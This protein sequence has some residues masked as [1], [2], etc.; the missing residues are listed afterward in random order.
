MLAGMRGYYAIVYVAED[1][2]RIQPA[3]IERRARDLLAA[4]PLAEAQRIAAGRLRIGLSTHRSDQAQAAIAGGA[5]YIGFG[6]IFDTRSKLR[7][8]PTVGLEALRAV[9]AASPIP[10]VAIGGI[11]L[12]TVSAVAAAGA[13]AAAV[14]SAVAGAPDPTAAGRAVAAAFSRH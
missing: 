6:P 7:P 1:A 9:C 8:D 12:D 11:T 5:D 4:L 2:D 3:L 14:I 13:S 10:V